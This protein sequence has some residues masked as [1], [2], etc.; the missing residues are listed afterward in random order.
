MFLE[1]PEGCRD[2]TWMPSANSIDIGKQTHMR[3]INNN[4]YHFFYKLEQH[5]LT[6]LTVQTTPSKI[7]YSG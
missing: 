5:V 7:S 2:P 6:P 3:L 1:D 4:R